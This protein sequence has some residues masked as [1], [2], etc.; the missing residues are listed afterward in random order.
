MSDRVTNTLRD[1]TQPDNAGSLWFGFGGAGIAWIVLGS[2]DLLITW[3]VCELPQ[4]RVNAGRGIMIALT[5]LL[6]IT[7]IG[8]GS[9]GYRTWRRASQSPSIEHSHA[10]GREEFMGMVGMLMA[11]SLGLG[12]VWLGLPLAIVKFCARAR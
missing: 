3:W 9:T 2:I 10:V 11:I 6:L 12:I 4:S 7:A 5:L 8:A 1:K